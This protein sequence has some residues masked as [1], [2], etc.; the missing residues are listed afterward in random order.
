MTNSQS[1]VKRIS[2]GLGETWEHYH[3]FQGNKGYF[4]I[5]LREQG[6]FLLL[7]GTLNK[8]I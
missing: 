1:S 6:M 3:L 4:G 7:N 8:N 5:N 2:Q